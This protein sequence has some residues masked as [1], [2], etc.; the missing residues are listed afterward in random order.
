M[1]VSLFREVSYP[2]SKLIEDIEMGEIGLPEIQRPFVWKNVKVRDL[3]DSMYR[4][5]PIGYLL[6]WSNGTGTGHLQIGMNTKQQK[7]ARLLIVDGQQRLTS[8]FAVIKG[9]PVVRENFSQE[10][11]QIAFQP[12]EKRFE[13][14]DAAIRRDPAYITDISDLWS[15]E[16]SRNRFVKDYL[17]RLREKRDVS[18]SQEDEIIEAI[19]RLYDLKN[20]RFT[21]LELSANIDEEQVAE[22][23]VRINSSGTR[24]NQADFILTLMSVFWDEGRT[25]LENFCRKARTPTV[26][27]KPSPYNRFI[28]PNP[29]QMLRVSI[30]L[31]F[32]RARLQHVY[33]IL[34]G[35]DLETGEFSD[36]RRVSQFS[37]LQEAQSRTVDVGHWHEFLKCLTYAGFRS[38]S[39]FSSETALLYNYVFYLI[40]RINYGVKYDVLRR[41]IA[42][43]FFMSQVTSRY[44]GS[45]ESTMEQDLSRLR[46]ISTG[47]QFVAILDRIVTDT[48]TDD[49]WQITLP[50]ELDSSSSNN[51]ASYAY[52]AALILLE[53]RGL[54]SKLRIADLYDPSVIG[55][56]TPLERHHLFPKA[57]LREIGLGDQRVTNQ[58]ANYALVEWHDNINIGAAPPAEYYGEMASRFSANELRDMHYWHALPE[59]WQNMDYIEF[60]KSRRKLMAEVTRNGFAR[61]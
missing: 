10:R 60:L 21:A 58:H 22:I 7:I 36:E 4:G 33:S 24:L 32:R 31:G 55:T 16:Q 28:Q 45:F 6:L 9:V 13:V 14:A 30:G 56:K 47:D 50:N 54:F 15:T 49:F 61:L 37:V 41:V 18:D 59:N 29:D 42:R 2:L 53:A 43:W 35:K 20:Y 27:G 8:L 19:D 3:F 51:P 17:T 48:L 39:M 38:R 12:I 26:D 40:G 25:E 57:Y 5:F 23:F 52:Q 44:S 11:I 46:D 1:S 34:R